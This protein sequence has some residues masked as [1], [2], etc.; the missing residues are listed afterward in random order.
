MI[1]LEYMLERIIEENIIK[2]CTFTTKETAKK[3][4][5]NKNT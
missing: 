1:I 4:R 5:K 3:K 2:L